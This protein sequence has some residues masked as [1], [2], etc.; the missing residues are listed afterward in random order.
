MLLLAGPEAAY[1]AAYLGRL[2]TFDS[3]ATVRLQARGGVVGIYGA[4]APRVLSL[5]VVPLV[6]PVTGTGL[7]GVDRTLSAGRLRDVL[8]TVSGER[9]RELRLPDPV[10]GSAELSQLPP[11]TGWIVGTEGSAG[12]AVPDAEAAPD[13][14]GWGGLSTRVLDVA[15]RLALLSRP[16]AAIRASATGTAGGW[17]RLETP[18]GQVFA[19]SGSPNLLQPG[20]QTSR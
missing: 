8:G 14:L 20:P 13:S 3:G 19:R 18:A 6:E 7:D 4:P 2:R 5:V 17:S 12:E 1:V 11:R 16:D 9:A 15:Q 10:V